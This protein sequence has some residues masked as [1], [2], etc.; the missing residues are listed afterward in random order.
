LSHDLH[1]H[2][3]CLKSG[4]G[5]RLYYNRVAQGNMKKIELIHRIIELELEMFLAVPTQEKSDCQ[6]YPESFRLHRRAQFNGWSESTLE[7]YLKDLEKAKAE[8]IN[9]MTLKYARMNQ[10]SPTEQ[11]NPLIQK[12]V[13]M[14]CQWQQEMIEKYPNLMAGARPISSKEDMGGSTS[15]ETYLRGELETYSDYTLSLLYKDITNK[16]EKGINMSEEVYSYLAKELGYGSAEEADRA[17]K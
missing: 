9:L 17:Q 8:G 15:F 4:I 14:Q 2:N 11:H 1:C 13:S 12:I 5:E 3:A 10:G 16:V 7:S 6:N